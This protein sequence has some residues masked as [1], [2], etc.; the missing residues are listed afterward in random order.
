MARLLEVNFI[1][2]AEM[3]RTALPELR[4]GNQP[5]VVNLG[6][7]LGHFALPNM[8]AY[9]A[10][11]FAVRGFSDA[12]RGE[13]RGEVDVLLATPATTKSEFFDDMKEAAAKSKW[14]PANPPSAETVALKIVQ[15]MIA[16]KRDVYPPGLPG[17]AAR[18]N[19]M[20]PRLFQG[21]VNRW[22]S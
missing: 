3:T 8:A 9:S 10:S 15:A 1:A 12:I 4:R 20:A 13:L 7:V 17:A 22:G 6:S 16:G 21:I 11:K 2:L 19:Q 5:L 14:R 18:F